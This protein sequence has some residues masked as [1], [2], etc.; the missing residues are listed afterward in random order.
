MDHGPGSN[1]FNLVVEDSTFVG[2]G[3]RPQ[4]CTVPK[5]PYCGPQRCLHIELAWN[6]PYYV[7]SGVRRV[8]LFSAANVSAFGDQASGSTA[9]PEVSALRLAPLAS[10]VSRP[11]AW[12]FAAGGLQGWTAVGIEAAVVGGALSGSIANKVCW[13]ESAPT[14]SN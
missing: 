3:Q 8:G 2:N 4:C 12:D 13:L 9:P 14:W 7:A 6:N 11:V 5:Q 1:N 10:V